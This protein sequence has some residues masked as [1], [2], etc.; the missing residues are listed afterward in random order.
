M[1]TSGLKITVV[2]SYPRVGESSGEQRLR[3][4]IEAAG[5]GALSAQELAKVQD[6]VTQEVLAE[7]VGAGVDVLTDGAVRWDDAVSYIASKIRGFELTGLLRYFDTNCYYRQPAAVEKVSFEKPILVGDFQLASSLAKRPVKVLLT[8]PYT[9]A[10]LSRHDA[11]PT[12]EAFLADLAGILAEEVKAL[13]G[14]GATLLQ[15]DEPAI[16]SHPQD[17][18]VFERALARVLAAAAGMETTLLLNYGRLNGL[19]DRVNG[20]AFE[21]LALDLATEPT[22]VALVEKGKVAKKVCA[23]ILNARNTRMEGEQ[24]TK[25]LVQKLGRLLGERLVYL[26]PNY[27]LEFLPRDTARKKLALLRSLA[28]RAA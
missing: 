4:A 21:I 6:D 26:A 16:L 23:G 15:V 10:R 5:R 8:G 20:L 22:H 27:S 24:E 13:K 18:P 1:A 19:A 14:A 3:R 25:A 7:Q 9:I 2:G 11:Y 12:F 28:P 17:W